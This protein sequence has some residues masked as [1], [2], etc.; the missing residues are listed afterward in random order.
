MV[1]SASVEGLDLPND[2]GEVDAPTSG[3][4]GPMARTCEHFASDDGIV[5][6]GASWPLS[7]D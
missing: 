6:I 1:D 2:A 5:V 3:P 4:R 7:R